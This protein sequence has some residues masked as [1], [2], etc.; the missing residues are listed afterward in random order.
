MD[1]MTF[2]QFQAVAP[3]PDFE[4]IMGN[5]AQVL[6]ALQSGGHGGVIAMANVFPSLCVSIV[7]NYQA[8]NLQEAQDAQRKVMRLRELVRSIMPIMSHKEILKMQG[9]EMGPAR[10][11][12][13]D[14]NEKETETLKE[15]L[16]LIVGKDFFG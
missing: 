5:D 11:P 4:I 12:L 15:K 9:F 8:G 7:E 1:F 10:F 2:L 3:D 6:T 16:A 14:L 13:R